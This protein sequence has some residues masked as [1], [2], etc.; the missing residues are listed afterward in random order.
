MWRALAKRL[1][2][3]IA[4][5]GGGVHTPWLLEQ[6]ADIPGVEVACVLDDR[7]PPNATV[8]GHAVRRPCEIDPDSVAAVVLSSWHQIDALRR[9]AVE[10]FAGRVEIVT[11]L[12]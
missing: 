5:F 11:P 4:L 6:V 9:R 8:A 2:G 3:P 7:I 1:D 12:D 10:V